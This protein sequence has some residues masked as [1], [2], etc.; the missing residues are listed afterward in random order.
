MSR[1]DF[2]AL[3]VSNHRLHAESLRDTMFFFHALGIQTMILTVRY[4]RERHTITDFS[5]RMRKLKADI[6]KIRPRG[7]KLIVC[8]EVSLTEGIAD[9]PAL[10]R[11]TA[12]RSEYLFVNLP[13]FHC[14]DWMDTDLNRILFQ[15]H[16]RPIFTG[17]ESN[18][19]TYSSEQLER[20]IHSHSFI[21]CFDVNYLT[22]LS[23][24]EPLT[25]MIRDGIAVLPCISHELSDYAGVI[26]GFDALKDSLGNQRYV[27]LC[28][29]IQRC[30]H[31]VIARIAKTAGS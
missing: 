2:N 30:S 24:H 31:G 29:T 6:R 21:G 22:S 14:D 26:A 17:F 16:C 9:D 11:L 20:L 5:E 3:I 12:N 27:E 28:R 10:S 25:R 23:A 19:K 8:P 7:M 13:L 1:L 18:M 4:H 15:K